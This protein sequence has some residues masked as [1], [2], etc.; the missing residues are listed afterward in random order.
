[1]F[2]LSL[3]LL[4]FY[5]CFLIWVFVTGSVSSKCPLGPRLKSAPL[6]EGA[7]VVSSLCFSCAMALESVLHRCAPSFE[8][9]VQGKT[10]LVEQKPQSG[11]EVTEIMCH[12]ASQSA[13]CMPL[14]WPKSHSLLS[15]VAG[16]RWQIPK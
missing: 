6:G 2:A 8:T 3:P 12:C 1:M 11:A 10:I 13:Q 7:V 15:S 5:F 14:V 9:G 4:V 16:D